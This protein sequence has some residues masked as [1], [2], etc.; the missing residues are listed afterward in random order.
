[1]FFDRGVPDVL[2]YLRVCGVAVPPHMERAATEF[3]YGTRVFITPPWPEIYAADAERRQ[4][5]GEARR[6]YEAM[7]ATYTGCGYAPIEVPRAPVEARVAFV[8][9]TVT[10]SV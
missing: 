8:L 3:R 7:V 2:G 6:T 5:L 10:G 1:M 4:S 9:A